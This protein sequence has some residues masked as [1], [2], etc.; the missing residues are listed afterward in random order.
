MTTGHGEPC[1]NDQSLFCLNGGICY[2]IPSFSGPFCKCIGKYTGVRCEA[3]FLAS[4]KSQPR[5]EYL[6]NLLVLAV[7][8][9]LLFIGLICFLCRRKFNNR[10]EDE[11]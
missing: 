6:V 3:I 7:F 9:G 1:E 5:N 4:E 11:P 8:L 10:S 2:V